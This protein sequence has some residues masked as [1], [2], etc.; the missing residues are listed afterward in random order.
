MLAEGLGLDRQRRDF[1]TLLGGAAAALPLAARA[2]QPAMPVIGYLGIG[3][4]RPED[5][6]GPFRQ[7]L[8]AAGLP[9]G[10]KLT[11]YYLR[12]ECKPRAF[13]GLPAQPGV[14]QG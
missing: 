9:E 5:A 10:Q 2:Q 7:G 3:S 8:R 11:G 6:P 12:A 4:S 1:I 13:H 14:P